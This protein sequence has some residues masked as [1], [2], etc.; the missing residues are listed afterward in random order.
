M[1]RATMNVKI[2][3]ERIGVL[4]GVNG[5]VKKKIEETLNVKLKIDSESGDVQIILNPNTE[6]P[7]SIFRARDVVLAIGRGFSPE[8]AF[9]LLENEEVMLRIIDLKDIFGRSPSNFKRVKGRVIGKEGKTRRLIEELTGAQVSVYGK[10]ISIIGTPEEVEVAEEAIK[11][12]IKG[13]MHK[14]VYRYL[15]RRKRELKRR[16]AFELWEGSE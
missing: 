16:M 10:T 9:R 3:I 2:P 7:S 5:N 11:M 13:A 6:D 14:T 1:S 4:I 15:F 8:R 12:L